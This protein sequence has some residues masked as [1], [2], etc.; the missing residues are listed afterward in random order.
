MR[1]P[2]WTGARLCGGLHRRSGVI[3]DRSSANFL[4]TRYRLGKRNSRKMSAHGLSGKFH[5]D[6][7]MMCAVLDARTGCGRRCAT[8]YAAVQSNG[9][10]GDCSISQVFRTSARVQKVDRMSVC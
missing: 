1:Y 4:G 2:V 6:S 10:H 9:W 7:E 5:A 8:W 3:L